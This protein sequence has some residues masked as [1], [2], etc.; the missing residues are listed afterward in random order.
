[1]LLA[2]PWPEFI[3]LLTTLCKDWEDSIG[4]FSVV[5][6]LGLHLMVLSHASAA[7]LLPCCDLT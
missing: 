1:M 3:L 6:R 7:V 2:N 4:S 5:M